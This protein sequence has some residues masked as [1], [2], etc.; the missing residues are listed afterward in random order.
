MDTATRN[1]DSE[2]YQY[3]E[4]TYENDPYY[5][6][7]IV[8][9]QYDDDAINYEEEF[10]DRSSKLKAAKK[11]GRLAA[12]PQKNNRHLQKSNIGGILKKQQAKDKEQKRRARERSKK[13]KVPDSRQNSRKEQKRSLQIERSARKIEKRANESTAQLLARKAHIRSRVERQGVWRHSLELR[14]FRSEENYDPY[15]FYDAAQYEK[16]DNILPAQD[17]GIEDSS[18]YNRLLAIVNGDDIKPEDFDMLLQL[19]TNN[20]K[21]T[22]DV[23]EVSKFGVSIVDNDNNEFRGEQC[24]I[25]LGSFKEMEHGKA[26]RIL[27]CGHVFCTE[28]IDHWLT[29]N[30]VRCPELSCFWSEEKEESTS[31]TK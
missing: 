19:D 14:W 29:N 21:S 10:W 12:R 5:E 28:C 23:N 27:P 30:S 26:L 9:M 24:S 2:I 3:E 18:M 7:S 6:F 13:S 1:R 11:G 22:M 16:Q 17:L 4:S 20:A 8:P 15:Q 31:T 25:C